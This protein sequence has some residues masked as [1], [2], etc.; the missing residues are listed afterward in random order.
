MKVWLYWENV[1]DRKT[2]EY[3]KLC[4]EAIIKHTSSS[5]GEVVVVNQNNVYTYLPNLRRDINEIRRSEYKT[6]SDNVSIKSAYIRAKLIYEYGGIWLDSDM[7]PVKNFEI[8]HDYLLKKDFVGYR[9]KS[10]GNDY[11]FIGFYGAPKHSTI[12]K[13]YID[14]QESI[15][16]KRKVLKWGE[17]GAHALTPIIKNNLNKCHI[18]KGKSF[19]PLAYQ[20]WNKFFKNN[21][22]ETF[23]DESTICFTLYNNLFPPD[24][25][26]WNREKILNSDLMI[27]KILRMS[28]GL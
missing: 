2:P 15:I 5:F 27:S 18:F 14:I 9:K 4:R 11:F 16:S 1:G 25:K 12:V 24:F 8:V 10:F 22:P 13:D 26:E 20:E 23:M 17:I 6:Y 19:Q 3:I 28:L 7:V 21:N